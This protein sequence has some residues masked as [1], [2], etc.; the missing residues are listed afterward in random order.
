M[1]YYV[2]L[3]VMTHPLVLHD[4]FSQ[5]VIGNVFRFQNVHGLHIPQ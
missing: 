2:I 1:E 3:A 5:W 4:I